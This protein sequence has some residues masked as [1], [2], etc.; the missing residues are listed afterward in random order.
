L[1][2][3][4]A[5]S[6]GIFWIEIPEVD[7]RI[8]CGCPPDAVKHLTRRGLILPIEIQGVECE[9]GPNAI[10]LSDL[11]L[12]NGRVCNRS[13]FPVLQMLYKQGMLLPHHPRNTG[14]RPLL[15]GSRS[16]VDAQMS[17]LFRGNYGLASTEELTETGVSPALAAEIMQMKLGFA[18][19]RIRSTEELVQPVYI[20][21]ERTEIRDGVAVRRLRTNVFEISH[22]SERVTVDL[23]LGRGE[24]YECP[25]SLDNHLLEHDY[26]TIVHNG[27]GD[28]WDM[29]RPA[30]G[31][32]LLFQGR[33]YLVDAG[34]NIDF[35]LRALGIG[36][37]EIDGVFHTHCHDDHLL[38]LTTLLRGDR[39]LSYFA[40]PMVRA[41]VVKKLSAA[42]QFPE[43]EF[44]QLFDVHDLELDQWN[45]I[46]G[47]EVRPILSPHPV[48]TTI[49]YFRV[50]WE[51]GYRSYGH[52]ADIAS[53][54]VMREMLVEDN[55]PAGISRA[56]FNR[57]IDAYSQPVDVK[58]IDI[59]GEL[60]HG[61]A[62]DFR[63]DRSGKLILAHTSRRLTDEERAIGSGAPFATVDVLIKGSSDLFRRRAYQYLHSYF[64]DVPLHRL[65]HLL[66]GEVVVFNP[67]VLLIRQ[68]S[69]V[70]NLYLILSGTVESLRTDGEGSSVLSA[71]SIL[72]ESVA[73]LNTNAAESYRA[74]SFV[75]AL[76]LPRDLYLDF[77]TR[78]ALYQQIVQGHDKRE[79][80][81]R[82]PLFA[83]GVSCM[84]LGRLVQAAEDCELKQRE[85]T[86]PP[87]SELLVIRSGSLRLA[88]TTGFEEQLAAGAHFGAISLAPEHALAT[89]VQALEPVHAYRF[90]LSSLAAVPVVRWKLL[91]THRRRYFDN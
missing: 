40:V 50:L 60:I 43:S 27:D 71:G 84:T 66:N 42:M 26:F 20:G 73:L 68:G 67:E 59:G 69:P 51:G 29:N 25:Y 32:I 65:R 62:E 23:N 33:V 80:L 76:R 81:R 9:S 75:R 89:K 4:I 36:A 86:A 63:A 61:M 21:A 79:F 54:S 46:E 5:V 83:D 28:G 52:L 38:G 22:R 6:T 85:Q 13:E 34:P 87:E 24:R 1:I 77:V 30:M 8:L 57:T 70:D 16:Q 12:Q 18:F 91:E 35:S 15:L 14:V 3:K 82:V 47:L 10:L 37:N 55:A 7:L 74:V 58:K 31:S 78:G 44:N 49:M 17:Y 88:T 45:D 64:A 11:A 53:L 56:L 19:G 72:G 39:R 48:E 2:R 90:P 41:S